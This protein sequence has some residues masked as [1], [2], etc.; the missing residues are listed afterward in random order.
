MSAPVQKNAARYDAL[1]M[2]RQD[3]RANLNE[4]KILLLYTGGT[5]G[6]VYK[7]H[8][9]TPEENYFSNTLRRNA[10]FHDLDEYKRRV[11]AGTMEITSFITPLTIYGKRIVYDL[12]ELSPLIDSSNL[13]VDKWMQITNA[14]GEYYYSYDALIVLHGTDTMAYSASMLSFIMEGLNKPIILTGS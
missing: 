7:E 9:Y 8:G 4:T 13:N 14:I 12:V 10:R 3:T 11:A 6:M 1:R 2:A 5:I